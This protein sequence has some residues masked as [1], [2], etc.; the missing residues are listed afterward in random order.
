MTVKPDL[1]YIHVYLQY[2]CVYMYT[3]VCVCFCHGLPNKNEIILYRVVFCFFFNL[4]SHGVIAFGNPCRV[5]DMNNKLCFMDYH[6][7]PLCVYIFAIPKS[8]TI[9]I[10]VHISLLLGG[11]GG[12]L[13]MDIYT[14]ERDC[15]VKRFMHFKF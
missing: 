6:N 15:W 4:F 2:T 5:A 10:W 14:Q 8:T 11:F 9:N 12:L 7:F 3:H 13:S 1:I